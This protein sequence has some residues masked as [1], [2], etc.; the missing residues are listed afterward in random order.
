M[1]FVFFA[2]VFTD[3]EVVGLMNVTILVVPLLY[4]LNVSISDSLVIDAQE[5]FEAD[6]PALS[7]VK[8]L[9]KRTHLL[10]QKH[11][12]LKACHELLRADFALVA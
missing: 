9:E 5:I 8:M 11:L 10:L 4:D 7:T 6:L 2:S 3:V 1:L 12:P